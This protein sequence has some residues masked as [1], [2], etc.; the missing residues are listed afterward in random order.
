MQTIGNNQ[1]V[2]QRWRWARGFG[3]PL[4]CD[5][6]GNRLPDSS[7]SLM[8]CDTLSTL[9]RNSKLALSK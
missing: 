7:D 5:S 4:R 6:V 2:F 8:I 1:C 9:K 3:L